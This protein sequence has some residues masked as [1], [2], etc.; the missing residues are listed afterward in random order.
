MATLID[1]LVVALGIDA[2]GLTK[3]QKDASEALK[4]TSDQADRTAKELEAKGKQAA[5]FFSQI[6]NQVVGLFAV[7]TAGKGLSSFVSD[8]VAADA[9][10]GR[11]A[12]NIGLSTEALSAWQGVAE[13]AG[14]SASGITGTLRNI[15]SQMQQI[16]LTGT[17][18]A[19]VLQSLAMAGINVSKYFD[20]A[21]SS[22]ERLL[23]ASDAFSHMDAARAQALGAG[24]GFDEGTIN[25]LMQGRQAVQA[26]LAEQEKIGHTNEE[27]AKSAMQLQAA[28]RSLEQASTDLGRKI[29]TSLSPY[30]Q[31][32]SAALLKFSEWAETHRPMVEAAFFGL[33]AAV[34]AFAVALAAPLAGMAALSAG[35]GVAIAMIA[36]LYDDWKTWID[37]GQSAFGGFWQFFA[38]KWASISGVVTPVFDSLKKVFSDWISS[39]TDLLKLVVALFT[40]SGDDIRKAWIALV[41]DL[42]KY[43]TDWIGLIKNLGPAIL[44]A[45]K[46]AFV[47]AFEWVKDRARAVWDAITGKHEAAAAA[48][49]E[50]GTGAP[51]ANGARSSTVSAGTGQ[52]AL[53]DVLQAAKQAEAKYGVPAGITFAQWA[54]ESNRG[55]S[56]PEGSNNPFGIK[57]KPGQPFVEAMTDEFINGQKVRVMQKFAKF[58]TLADAFEAHAKLLATGKPYAAARAHSDDPNAYADALTGVYATDPKYGAKLKKI[59]ASVDL[60]N[61]ARSSVMAAASSTQTGSMSTTDVKIGQLNVHTQATDATA[62]AKD[63]GP[64]VQKYAFTVQSNTGLI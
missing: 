33:A 43:F 35:I 53:A 54:L 25:V 52:S 62:I 17:P 47:S 7:F 64:A 42:G 63:I 39:V 21:T 51:P 59:M 14:G 44:A 19:Q 26:L 58:D 23:M 28:W 4:K 11:V 55:K 18:G 46:T 16:A 8:V 22:S 12:K 24:M 2:S 15:S 30:I 38:D 40:G 29:L 27:D 41:G 60:A 31:D 34:T 13:R 6:K 45:F 9:A 3:G 20:K 49:S 1:S 56:M 48:P 36:L 10:V 57:A 50:S 5:Q 61:G 37:G 32:L